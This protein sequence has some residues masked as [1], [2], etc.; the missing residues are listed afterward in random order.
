MTSHSPFVA[1]AATDG[2]LIV[3]RPTGENG[4]VELFDPNYRSKAGGPI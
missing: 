1:Q 4:A 3:M 2:G